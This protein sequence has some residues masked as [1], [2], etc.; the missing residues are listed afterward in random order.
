MRRATSSWVRLSCRR[1]SRIRCPKVRSFDRDIDA[2]PFSPRQ[3][4]AR[5]SA[6]ASNCYL[7]PTDSQCNQPW[8]STANANAR[9]SGEYPRSLRPGQDCRFWISPF[10]DRANYRPRC[11]HRTRPEIA[12]V[13]T[14]SQQI[15]LIDPKTRTFATRRHSVSTIPSWKFIVHS[16]GLYNFYS[17][18][19]SR[20]VETSTSLA[21]D[22]LKI[23]SYKS[24]HLQH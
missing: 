8:P 13:L 18:L 2:F 6:P 20:K 10:G 19:S 12:A 14:G 15:H 9:F 11:H 17:L 23:Q 21:H 22:E 16:A 7:G 24:F 3:Q 4:R 5:Q 1:R